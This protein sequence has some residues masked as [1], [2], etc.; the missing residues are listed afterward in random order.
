MSENKEMKELNKE[1]LDKV[2]GGNIIDDAI[3]NLTNLTNSIMTNVLQ[4]QEAE[5]A[6][7]HNTAALSEAAK[8]NGIDQID[9]PR[10]VWKKGIGW[11]KQK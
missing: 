3:Y 10:Y 9:H 6:R 5:N 7:S 1:K 2:A 11:I 4:K 8:E